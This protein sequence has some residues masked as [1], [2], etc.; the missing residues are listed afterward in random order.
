M[1]SITAG[2][3]S[4]QTGKQIQRSSPI[5]ALTGRRVGSFNSLQTGK[6]IQS[7]SRAPKPKR[8]ERV[9]FQFPSNGKADPKLNSVIDLLRNQLF[10]FPSNGKADPKTAG[11]FS[12]SDVTDG[13]QFPSNGKADPK[14][15]SPDDTR[16]YRK[17]DCFNSLQTGKQIQRISPMRPSETSCFKF[18]FPSNGK[19]DPK[20]IPQL[21]KG[22]IWVSIPFKREKADPKLN[23]TAR[24]GFGSIFVSIPF[25]R[26]SRSKVFVRASD[27]IFARMFQFP[28]NGKADPKDW[29]RDETRAGTKVSIP[30]KR[31]SRSK[32]THSQ[33][34]PRMMHCF[35]SL[36]TGKQ[37]QSLKHSVYKL[38]I[39]ICF[40][41]L[42]TG[43]QIQR[44]TT[45]SFADFWQGGFQFPS[46]GK[47]DPK[48]TSTQG[49][50]QSETTGFNSLQ[51]GKQIQRYSGLTDTA[52]KFMSV[53][54]PFKRE[55]RSKEKEAVRAT[56]AI[57]FQ[58]PSNGKADPKSV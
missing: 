31:E 36:Q 47:A 24:L 33:R 56:A 53:S 10:Q 52:Q 46:N 4:L 14:K 49:T 32:G 57:E 35:N 19:A 6:Q 15:E 58:F 17:Y 22:T 51:T 48:L 5:R 44:I 34:L 41:S 21:R 9:E 20:L 13:F 16:K 2:F 1:L 8:V 55:S 26:E 11:T 12:V 45:V 39:L 28:S 27:K 3:N 7:I 25:K 30:F 38:K 42:Q 50:G 29:K 18:Q 43:K 54:I 37:I 40:N 23:R